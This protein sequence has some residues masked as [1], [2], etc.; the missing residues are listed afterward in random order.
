VIIL[1]NESRGVSQILGTLNSR[2]SFKR[3]GLDELGCHSVDGSRSSIAASGFC[4][5]TGSWQS[6]IQIYHVGSVSSISLIIGPVS[7]SCGQVLGCLCVLG[8][9]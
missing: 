9:N 1:D 4:L 5:S 7:L 8:G 3:R 6:A 2:A